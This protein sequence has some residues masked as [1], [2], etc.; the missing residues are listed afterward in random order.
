MHHKVESIPNESQSI[1]SNQKK[2]FNDDVEM[3][4]FLDNLK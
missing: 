1:E 3:F 2:V 4:N